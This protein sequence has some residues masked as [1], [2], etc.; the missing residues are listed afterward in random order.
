MAEGQRDFEAPDRRPSD[1]VVREDEE[2]WRRCVEEAPVAIAML[3]EEMCY[4]A[5]SERWRAEFNLKGSALRGR[6][7]YELFP[8]I[9]ER[10]KAIHQ[11]CLAGAVEHNDEDLFVR[12]DGSR[13]WLRWAIRPWRSDAGHVGGLIIYSEDITSR[14]EG[15]AALTESERRL[16]L[17]LNASAAGIWSWDADSQ[18]STWDDRYHAQYGFA[19]GDARAYDAWVARLHP[20]DRPKVMARL[21]QMLQTPG[22][23]EWDVEFRAVLPDGDIRWMHGLGRAERDGDGRVTRL[24]GINLDVTAQKRAE[25]AL[26]RS[27][28]RQHE[29]TET[30]RLLLETAAQGIVSVD[31]AGV[32][33]TAN[34]AIAGMFGWATDELIGQS[35]ERLLPSSLREAHARHRSA[36]FA[37]PRPRPMGLGMNLVGQRKDGSTFPVEVSLNHTSTPTG[38]RAIAFVTDV[39]ARVRA[40]TALRDSNRRLR[41]ALDAAAAETWTLDLG[42]STMVADERASARPAQAFDSSHPFARFL[43]QVHPDDRARVAANLEAVRQP[44]GVKGCD[45]EYRQIQPDGRVTWHQSVA[46]VERDQTRHAVRISGIS[47]DVTARKASEEEVQRSHMA[48]EDR[49]AELERRTAQLSRLATD[50]TL[51]EQHARE[52]LAKTLH[53]HLQQLL[54]GATLKLDRLATRAAR[55]DVDLDLVASARSDI[56]DA[57]AAA[58]SLSVELFPPALHERGLPAALEWLAGWMRQKYGLSVR[59][60]ADA[61]ANPGRHDLRILLFE[62]CKELLF[63]VVKH[64]KTNQVAVKV[65]LGPHQTLCITVTDKGAGFDPALTFDVARAQ[66]PGL[67]L[68]SIRERLALLGGRLDIESAPGRGA[69]FTLVAPRD[70]GFDRPVGERALAAPASDDTDRSTSKR[71]LRILIADDHAIVREGLRELLAGETG[72]QVVGVASDGLEAIAQAHALRPDIVVMDVSMP[73]MDGVE[74]TRRIRA[75]LPFIDVFGL[76]THESTEELHPIEKAGAAGYFTKGDDVRHLVE[77]L[78]AVH[79]RRSGPADQV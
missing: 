60:S 38:E 49:T 2:H 63:N 54:F 40:D 3:D 31:V 39:T 75:E 61:Q 9:P 11:R 45:F 18:Q 17:A 24:V 70:G 74:A 30:V 42:A 68:F 43:E 56:D 50:L 55:G 26:Q 20:D 57:I 47:L 41:M 5:A 19:P 51:A 76:S 66:Q 29:T 77:R 13:Q 14:K 62:S 12:A 65:A 7:H 44:H 32:I 16:R 27:R 58:R 4:L 78:L 67:G 34:A 35:I 8:D 79:A 48:L 59:I 36:Y 37:A 64:A 46:R 21:N 53:D 52:Q 69:R 6:S 23:D 33:V 72:L 73:Q 22:D 1:G 28:D 71:P 25:D 15:E 10:W